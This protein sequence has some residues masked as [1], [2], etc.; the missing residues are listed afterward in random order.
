M[1]GV[2]QVR[3]EPESSSISVGTTTNVVT[4][5]LTPPGPP[6]PTIDNVARALATSRPHG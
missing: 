2:T 5:Q 1:T 6:T 4:C 3:G